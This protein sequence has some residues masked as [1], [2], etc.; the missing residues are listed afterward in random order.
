MGWALLYLP[1]K[2]QERLLLWLGSVW[3]AT[4]TC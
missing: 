4:F 1:D 3:V 2:A